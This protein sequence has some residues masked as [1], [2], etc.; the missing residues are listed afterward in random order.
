MPLPP[1]YECEEL[2][3][4]F[5]VP[6]AAPRA[7][8]LLVP[9]N[10]AE[11]TFFAAEDSRPRLSGKTAVPAVEQAGGPLAVTGETPVFLWQKWARDQRAAFVVVRSKLREGK[12]SGADAI[13]Q[14]V[15]AVDQA[16]RTRRG[17]LV[18]GQG[19][20]AAFTLGLLNTHAD[21]LL[22]WSCEGAT[23]A[24]PLTPK[25]SLAPG[26][27]FCTA[28]TGT[29]LA[30]SW[31]TFQNARQSKRPWTWIQ[32]AGLAKNEA[33]GGFLREY[34]ARVLTAKNATGIWC[35]NQKREVLAASAAQAD[36]ANTSYLPAAALFPAWQ[37]LHAG[38]EI[39]A[40][41]FFERQV[42]TGVKEQPTLEL[43]L[44][45]P[46]VEPRQIAGV[47]AFNTW[48]RER[49][50]LLGRL[51]NDQD[52]LVRFAE[53]HR[54]ALLT[55]NTETLWRTGTGTEDLGRWQAQQH[56][57]RFD[58]VAAAWAKGVRALCREHQLPEKDFLLYGHSRGAHWG[59]R[60][61]LRQPEIFLAA[62]IHVA[63]SYDQPGPGARSLLWL[64]TTG[65]VDRGYQ[66]AHHFYHQARA[67]GY[68]ILLKAG[69]GLGHEESAEIRRLGFAFFEYALAA[70]KAREARIETARQKMQVLNPREPPIWA[71]DFQQPPYVGDF[72]NHLVYP[73]AQIRKIPPSQQVGIPS[74]E[75]ARA[76]GDLMEKKV[77]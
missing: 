9:G 13:P 73:A 68:P 43:Y 22:A 12:A 74:A 30:T 25:T 6:D 38:N 18:A 65:E 20:G 76:W 62:H 50:A 72:L 77:R 26:I 69:L 63:N 40:P 31:Q 27:L 28:A 33:A 42:E 34:F 58:D 4:F 11:A 59:H 67:L 10:F 2:E 44:R 46:A 3:L 1:T 21:R 61:A 56:D 32:G 14:V 47:L 15:A 75:L 41:R 39:K 51:K 53:K 35:H 64:V 36:L 19:A 48:A 17:L 71:K 70:K 45:L 52:S 60:L 5:F 24:V 37:A 66:A 29:P 7:V 8:L 55:W 54:L 23:L 57:A 49:E 16:L